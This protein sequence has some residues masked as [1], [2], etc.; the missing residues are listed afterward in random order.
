MVFAPLYPSTRYIHVLDNNTH[1]RRVVVGPATF[2]KQEHEK[3]LFSKPQAMIVLPPQHYVVI[4]SPAQREPSTGTGGGGGVKTKP[5]QPVIDSYGQVKVR[6][7]DREIRTADD[8]P[9][10]FPLYPGEEA[11]KILPL[12]VVEADQALVLKAQRPYVPR[13]CTDSMRS[14]A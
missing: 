14:R 11:G 10:P 12:T 9:A 3:I 6:F 8:F 1:C 2:T 13:C 5:G 7:G 4:D